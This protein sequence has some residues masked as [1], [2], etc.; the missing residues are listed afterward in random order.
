MCMKK[1][2]K[3]TFNNF[4][5]TYIFQKKYYKKIKINRDMMKIQK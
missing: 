1:N 4:I 3:M 2:K 5:S